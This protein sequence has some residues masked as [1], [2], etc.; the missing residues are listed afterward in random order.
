MAV[1]FL[2]TKMLLSFLMLLRRDIHLILLDR[3]LRELSDPWFFF[4]SHGPVALDSCFVCRASSSVTDFVVH[5]LFFDIIVC[6]KCDLNLHHNFWK[7]A[8]CLCCKK[9]D[10][11]PFNVCVNSMGDG[12]CIIKFCDSCFERFPMTDL[13]CHCCPQKKSEINLHVQP[14]LG[15]VILVWV[16]KRGSVYDDHAVFCKQGFPWASTNDCLHLMQLTKQRLESTLAQ[17]IKE[18]TW[19]C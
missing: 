15:Q 9:I 8:C 11:K 12:M 1:Q 17:N 3:T 14:Q 19:T 4:N 10:T 7:P 5:A 13:K 6:S 18:L 16:K 2:A